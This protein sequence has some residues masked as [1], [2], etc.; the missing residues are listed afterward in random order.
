MTRPSG[1]ST[2]KRCLLIARN[3]T[4]KVEYGYGNGSVVKR[5]HEYTVSK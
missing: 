5:T 3:W 1:V 2:E 4:S